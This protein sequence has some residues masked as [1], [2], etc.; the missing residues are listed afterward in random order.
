MYTYIY[1]YIHV[2]EARRPARG[3]PVAPAVVRG[4]GE[5]IAGAVYISAPGKLG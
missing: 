2:W 3:W 1:I 4:S 5:R